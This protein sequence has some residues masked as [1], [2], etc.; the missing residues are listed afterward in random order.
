[1]NI[2]LVFPSQ[3]SPREALAQAIRKAAGS[4]IEI[5]FEGDFLVCKSE[6]TV[7]LAWKLVDLRGIDTVAIAKK[8]SSEFSDVS[9]TIVEVGKK[10]ILPDKKFYVKVIQTSKAD[11]V[12]RDIEFASSGTLTAKLAGINA[13]PAKNED[14]A[15]KVVLTFIGKDAAYVCMDVIEGS[16]GVP[17]G[18]LGRASCSLHSGQSF[19]SCLYA[20]KAGFVPELVLLYADENELLEG[21]KIAQALTKQ[22]V[23]QEHRLR[24]VPIRIP[25][26]DE[27]T[28]NLAKDLI[29]LRILLHVSIKSIVLPFSLFTHPRWFIESII[30][31]AVLA[32]K[33]PYMPLMLLPD[34]LA[35]FIRGSPELC[36][37]SIARVTKSEFRKYNREIDFAV[38]SSLKRMKALK[39][40]VGPDYLH[41]ILDSI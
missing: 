37:R 5:S 35:N 27:S 41:D 7:E 16:G 39:L 11:Y 15:D 33:T 23:M 19:F 10:V 13:R 34:D 1:L 3:F 30:Q 21:A 4:K 8:V 28:V 25:A 38:R 22:T 24:L 17:F 32:D 20:V 6:D 14:E 26:A 31:E 29:A 18:L 36:A 40:K 9:N 2:V 12:D